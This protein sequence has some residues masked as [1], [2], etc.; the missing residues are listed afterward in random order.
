MSVPS[1]AV[2]TRVQAHVCAACS[3]PRCSVCRNRRLDVETC[4]SVHHG[5]DD[6]L[7]P[8]VVFCSV[9]RLTRCGDCEQSRLPL[10]YCCKKHHG[11]AP[12]SS[13]ARARSRFLPAP[14]QPPMG[15]PSEAV[16]ANGKLLVCVSCSKP[17]CSVCRNRRLEVETCCSVHHGSDDGLGP[18]IVFC[19]K[20]RLTRC[21]DCERSRLS[22]SSCCRKHHRSQPGATSA[23]T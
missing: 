17:R 9:H 22:L 13:H 8:A 14:G 20:H 3:K 6:G 12:A 21:G 15:V 19:T 4:C 23:V 16:Q 5:S 7:A 10:S 2:Q 1:D 11:S 18:A